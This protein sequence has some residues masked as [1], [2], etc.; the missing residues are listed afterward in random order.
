[1]K[2]FTTVLLLTLL[3]TNIMAKEIKT[4]IVI[5]ATPQKIW[6]ILTNTKAYPNWNP[7]I[8]SLEGNLAVGSKIK[9]RIEPPQAQAMTF[10]PTILKFETNKEFVWLGRLWFKGLFDGQHKFELIDNGDGTTTFI[11]SETFKGV[12][13]PLFS[14]MLDNNTVKGFELM[15]QKLK[16]LAEQ[17]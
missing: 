12:L 17:G 7:F 9:A 13:V 3:H 6:A 14:K 15:N 5:H 8:K 16:D 10:T 11:Q 4:S 2:I 1:M